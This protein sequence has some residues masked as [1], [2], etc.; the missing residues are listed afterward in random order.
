M[1]FSDNDLVIVN[2][3]LILNLS[4]TFRR[5]KKV[6]EGCITYKA[7]IDSMKR[8]ETKFLAEHMTP[9]DSFDLVYE[10]L[11]RRIFTNQI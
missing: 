1:Y 5:E 4:E 8:S 11:A 2:K 3:D 7:F 9:K 10:N 6:E